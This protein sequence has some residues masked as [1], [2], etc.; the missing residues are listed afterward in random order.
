MSILLSFFLFWCPFDVIHFLERE[1]NGKNLK[2]FVIPWFQK[3]K[4]TFLIFHC[5]ICVLVYWIFQPSTHCDVSE[6][7]VLYLGVALRDAFLKGAMKRGRGTCSMFQLLQLTYHARTTF[8]D[9]YNHVWYVHVPLNRPRY[10]HLPNRPLNR[11]RYVN[12]P[13]YT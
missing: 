10:V 4:F 8:I 6:I 12:V 7:F 5:F 9:I 1:K 3:L 11:P 2:I 13:W